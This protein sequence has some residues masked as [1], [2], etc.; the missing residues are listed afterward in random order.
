MRDIYNEIQKYKP[1]MG[2]Q[3]EGTI[4]M[5][6]SLDIIFVELLIERLLSRNTTDIDVGLLLRNVS[7]A[8]ISSG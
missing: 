6:F 5:C 3:M 7:M 8:S 4:L 1:G 2:S